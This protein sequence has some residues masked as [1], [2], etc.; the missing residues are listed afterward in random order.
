MTTGC[1]H[2]ELAW[3]LNGDLEGMAD[4]NF[5]KPHRLTKALGVMLASFVAVSSLVLVAITHEPKKAVSS[6]SPSRSTVVPIADVK[7]DLEIISVRGKSFASDRRVIVTGQGGV[8]ETIHFQEG[9]H[10]RKGDILAEYKLDPQSLAH[11]Y[12]VVESTDVDNSRKAEND[13]KMILKKLNDATLPLK[14]INRKKLELELK[15]LQEL[16]QKGLASEMAFEN[17]QRQLDVADRE[18]FEVKESIRQAKESV[19][20]AREN[21]K[22]SEGNQ[23]KKIRTLRTKR[24]YGKESQYPLDKA[25]LKAP[26][27]GRVF[28][29]APEFRENAQ[30]PTGFQAIVVGSIDPMLVRCKVHELDLVKLEQGLPGLVTFDVLGNDKKFRCKIAR[31]PWMSQNPALE[32]PADYDMECLLIDHPGSAIKS[33]FTCTVTFKPTPK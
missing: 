5:D 15:N 7:S 21:L 27:S 17:M 6:P 10:V 18:I 30:V 1:N 32:A 25:F 31:L 23:E 16:K 8:I 4:L 2:H 3:P 24:S 28:H 14:E 9:D 29:L 26:I 12:A 19:R 22:F 11:V 13:A 33:G 20:L